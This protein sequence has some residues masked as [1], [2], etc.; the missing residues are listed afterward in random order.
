[1]RKE[2]ELSK[3]QIFTLLKIFGLGCIEDQIKRSKSGDEDFEIYFPEDKK[4][5]NK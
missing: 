3:D 5:K 2:N 1:M 4:T